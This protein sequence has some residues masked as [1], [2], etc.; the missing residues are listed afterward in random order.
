MGGGSWEA[1]GGRI[2]GREAEASRVVR[3]ELGGGRW[4]EWEI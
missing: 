3:C 1:G 2:G 4:E